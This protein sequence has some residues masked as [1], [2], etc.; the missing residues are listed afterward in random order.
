VQASAKD[1]V[2][3]VSVT[4]PLSER[5]DAALKAEETAKSVA[6]VRQVKAHVVPIMTPD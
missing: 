6:G 4:A 1:G 3:F 2:V 5:E